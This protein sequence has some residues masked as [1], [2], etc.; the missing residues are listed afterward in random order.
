[1]PLSFTRGSSAGQIFLQCEEAFRLI[2]KNGDG[3]LSRIE[4]IQ[5][6]RNDG[7][8]ARLL[9]LPQQIKQEDG[10]RD[11]F[12]EIF[13][14]MDIDDSK[15]VDLQEF[16]TFW[17]QH[18][19]P[20]LW[21]EVTATPAFLRDDHEEAAPASEEPVKEA[22]DSDDAVEE[23][24]EE[25]HL[26]GA[27]DDLRLSLSPRDKDAEALA[28]SCSSVE[29]AK[30]RKIS[31]PNIPTGGGPI[32]PRP[33]CRS[34]Q[35]AAAAAAAASEYNTAFRSSH[36]RSAEAM[37]EEMPAPPRAQQRR[38]WVE[39]VANAAGAAAGAA[40]AGVAAAVMHAT[41]SGIEGGGAEAWAAVA[42]AAATSAAVATT[43]IGMPTGGAGGGYASH[44][45]S[46]AAAAAA[47]GSAAADVAAAETAASAAAVASAAAFPTGG[48]YEPPAGAPPPSSSKDGSFSRRPSCEGGGGAT[49][50]SRRPSK[51][52]AGVLD[53]LD[54]L[55]LRARAFRRAA[56]ELAAEGVQLPA[57]VA[58]AMP[59]SPRKANAAAT[60]KGYS[61]MRRP[62]ATR[63]ERVVVGR[64][65]PLGVLRS[66]PRCSSGVF[67]Q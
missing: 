25:H 16:Q 65:A 38:Q 56:E 51:T 49:H 1:M 20:H 43:T 6:C 18:V 29:K 24:K 22:A 61:Y 12:E 57:G 30:P 32:S 39:G 54:G 37:A 31:I 15:E 63:R 7:E 14:M 67:I 10:S 44:A 3:V 48:Y 42:I 64:Q 28:P 53:S 47:S 41:L 52:A 21:A 36:Q 60:A 35:D 34:A 27:S 40:A 55:A 13:Q 4:V 5:A 17:I 9:R 23:K 26:K 2:D 46:L 58:A 62:A 19:L 59:T 50:F 45:A 8:V 33:S 66:E 11:R